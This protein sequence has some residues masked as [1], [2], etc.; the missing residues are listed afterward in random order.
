MWISPAREYQNGIIIRYVI[1]VTVEE[2][3]EIYQLYTNTTNITATLTPF[4]MYT[5]VIT[6]E[7]SVGTGPYTEVVSIRSKEAGNSN[8]FFIVSS[9][10]HKSLGNY[11]SMQHI[12]CTLFT[13]SVPSSAPQ[14][15]TVTAFSPHSIT[16]H[17][18]PPPP[19]SQNGVIREYRVNVTEVETGM[20]FHF[21]TAAT[22]ITVPFLHPYYTYECVISAYTVATGPYAEVT[23]MTPE[24]G[25]LMSLLELDYKF[26]S[27]IS[28]IIL[29]SLIVEC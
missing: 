13:L 28:A 2:T 19:H 1:N 14:N 10:M 22:S 21:T 8:T 20:E 7:N 5:I 4:T 12:M 9:G 26:P 15:I 29:I 27:C 16:L 11:D 3:G 18:S 17:W 23:V 25:M 6:A 24:D